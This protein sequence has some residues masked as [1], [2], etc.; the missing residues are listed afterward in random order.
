MR[1]SCR[2]M[3]VRSKFEI[4]S[5]AACHSI[6]QFTLIRI[7]HQSMLCFCCV[8]TREK[9]SL[10]SILNPFDVD[11]EHIVWLCE[12]RFA[13]TFPTSLL[14]IYGVAVTAA[15][16]T[17]TVAAMAVVAFMWQHKHRN[18]FG[19]LITMMTAMI[20]RMWKKKTSF[21]HTCRCI[22]IIGH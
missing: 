2:R 7:K 21:W 16:A 13:A 12:N 17:A 6:L 9:K 20:I 11:R 19:K 3:H 10:K 4:S 22:S 14:Q 5:F 1:F 15:T 8:P 18:T